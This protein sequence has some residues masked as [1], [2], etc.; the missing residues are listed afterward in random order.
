MEE[1]ILMTLNETVNESICASQ[2]EANKYT[3]PIFISDVKK[4]PALLASSVVV[5]I[6]QKYYLIT[7]AHV[8]ENI[9]IAGSP[10]IIGVK[11]Q[12]VSI[13][14]G[15]IHSNHEKYDHFDIAY[16]ELS[17]DFTK[18]NDISSL[19]IGQLNVGN[20]F[21]NIRVAFIHGFPNSR[22]KQFRAL[23][24]TMSF[25]LRAYA[26]AGIIKNDFSS[27]K[28]TQKSIALHTCMAYTNKSD[29]KAPPDPRGISG[30]GLWIIPD[31][32]TPSNIYLD[33]ILIEYHKKHA[34]TFST[35]IN[36]V[37][38]FIMNTNGQKCF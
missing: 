11:G 34:M 3:Y 5:K 4:K 2:K 17:A 35:K 30:G 38:D 12:Y 9:V 6:K 26:Y 36:Q 37:V 20:K 33:S 18:A 13:E 14:G 31:I 1:L 21:P 16:I 24:N 8:L 29:G 28:E 25:R 10:F 23:L 7:A 32:S 22:N 19:N 27:W 15:F